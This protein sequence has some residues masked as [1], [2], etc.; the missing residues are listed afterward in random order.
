MSHA[1]PEE[2][3]HPR[4]SVDPVSVHTPCVYFINQYGN[5]GVNDLEEIIELASTVYADPREIPKEAVATAVAELPWAR[6]TH[7]Q[8]VP[9]QR[10]YEDVI[11]CVSC[12]IARLCPIKTELEATIEVENAEKQLDMVADGPSWLIAARLHNIH[13]T[14]KEFEA[15]LS[16]DGPIAATQQEALDVETLAGGIQNRQIKSLTTE[17]LPARLADYLTSARRSSSFDTHEIEFIGSPYAFVVSDLSPSNGYAGIRPTEQAYGI[18][19]A[20]LLGIM[21]E[22]GP[23]GRPAV[24]DANLQ[25]IVRYFDGGYIAEIRMGDKSRLYAGV[26]VAVIE[27][28]SVSGKPTYRLLVLGSHGDSEQA[29][30]D[31]YDQTGLSRLPRR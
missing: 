24:L 14:A 23:G 21:K 5:V 15:I 28:A 17:E 10:V 29:Q 30:Q 7:D 2:I 3:P 22:L 19:V 8:R 1:S 31:F 20:K 11:R 9:S 12:S 6:D 26:Y 16:D 18:L 13:M 4:A 25:K 27:T